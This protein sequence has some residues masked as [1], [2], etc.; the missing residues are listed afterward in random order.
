MKS[1]SK[2]HLDDSTIKKIFEKAGLSQIK[3]IEKLGDGEYNTIYCIDTLEKSYMLKVAPDDSFKHLA[4]ENNMM[5]GEIYWY[6]LMREKTDIPVPEIFFTDFSKSII[7]ASY[8]IM[9]KIEGTQK[10]K[11]PFTK[12]EKEK[13]DLQVIKQIADLH[14]IRSDK[15]G[16]VQ[17]TL[18]DNWY[19][20]YTNIVKGHIAD[21]KSAGKTAKYGKKLLRYAEKY[22]DILISVQCTAVNTDCWDTNIICKKENTGYKLYWIDPER[23]LWGDRIFDFICLD[24]M[25]PFEKKTEIIKKYNSYAT[26]KICI[27]EN[28]IIRYAFALGLLALVMDTEK[29]YRYTPLHFGWWRNVISSK[30]F[31]YSAFKT[32]KN[33]Y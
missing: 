22:K 23:S 29:Y 10:D 3:S 2:N 26:E 4:Y 7:P 11:T 31:Y 24:P 18:Y 19:D 25:Q 33:S 30:M 6:S 15:F 1:R 20:A 8:F 13:A 12:E 9:E 14:N 21:K 32:L 5:E 16:Y 27:G 28:E 17:S